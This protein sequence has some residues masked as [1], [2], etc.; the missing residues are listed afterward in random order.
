[1][2]ELHLRQLQ[3]I[4]HK[5]CYGHNEIDQFVRHINVYRF[6]RIIFVE[7]NTSGFLGNYHE[8]LYLPQQS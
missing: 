2:I 6:T 3:H 5:G 1:M 8:Q 7:M 4:Q